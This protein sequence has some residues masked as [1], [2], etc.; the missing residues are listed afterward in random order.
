MASFKLSH[1]RPNGVLDRDRCTINGATAFWVSLGWRR[2]P[3]EFDLATV[4]TGLQALWPYPGFSEHRA[5]RR[6]AAPGHRT[7]VRAAIPSQCQSRPGALHRGLCDE[8]PSGA[9]GSLSRQGDHDRIGP[10]DAPIANVSNSGSVTK[11]MIDETRGTA[12][13]TSAV[14]HSARLCFAFVPRAA[15]LASA[16]PRPYSGFPFLT[17]LAARATAVASRSGV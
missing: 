3:W 14:L 2:T 13:R 4:D 11:S 10:P 7:R 16:I 8:A 9:G 15:G 12:V 1:G 6:V 5:A 17:P